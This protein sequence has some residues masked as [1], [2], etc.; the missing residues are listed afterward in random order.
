[1]DEWGV[2]LDRRTGIIHGWQ[3]FVLDLNL[4]GRFE[5]GSARFS[6]H[7]RDG[8]AGV[9]DPA[10]GQDWLIGKGRTGVDPLAD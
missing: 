1:M 9:A 4:L 2:G 6:H 3:L 5:G 7:D 10:D 8:L